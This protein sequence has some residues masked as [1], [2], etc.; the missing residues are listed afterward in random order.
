MAHAAPESSSKP[1]LMANALGVF[2]NSVIGIAS[3]APAYSIATGIGGL[4]AAVGVA[5]PAL[6]FYNFFPMLGI[7]IG[8]YFLNRYYGPNAGGCYTWVSATMNRYLG[9]MTGWA[10]IAADVVFLVA[11]AVPAGVYTLDFFNPALANNVLLVSLVSAIWFILITAIVTRGIQITARFQWVLLLLEYLVVLA[12]SV[13]AF[14]R[15]LAEHPGYLIRWS[16]FTFHGN[17]ATFAGGATVAIFFYWGFDTITNLGEESKEARTNP[18]VA[19]IISTIALLIIFVVATLAIQSMLPVS[20]INKNSADVLDYIASHLAPRPWNYF[21]VL[22]VLSSTVATLETSLLPTAR[23]T[24][25][26]AR[27]RV[28]PSIFAA[29]HKRWLTPWIGT[30]I[31]GAVCFGGIFLMNLVS[32]VSTFLNGAVN[33]VGILVAYYYG[34]TAWASAWYLRRNLN[35]WKVL[36]FGFII[37]LLSGAFLFLMGVETVLQDGFSSA[38]PAVISFVIGI[39]LMLYYAWKSREFFR[40]PIVQLPRTNLNEVAPDPEESAV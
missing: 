6:L 23:V 16:W 17:F 10:I 18:G 15:G 24:F 39:P 35:N 26:M 40:L 34:I 32:S 36:V 22:A 12:F 1:R 29:V 3:T 21:M 8:F 30:L 9:Y 37:P 4:V 7:A 5:S 19:G 20:V 13:L 27:D 25:D 33:N 11:G 31:I 14:A 38:L 2:D 28:F